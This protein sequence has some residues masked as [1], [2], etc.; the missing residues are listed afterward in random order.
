MTRRLFASRAG[1]AGG[2]ALLLIGLLPAPSASAEVLR[3]TS[4][5]GQ[6]SYTDQSC[7]PGTRRS[8]PVDLPPPPPPGSTMP[9][10]TPTPATA[11]PVPTG[12]ILL[13]ARRTQPPAPPSAAAPD[14]LWSYGDPDAAFEPAARPLHRPARP[15]DMRPR[16]RNCDAQGCNDTQGNHYNHQGQLDR[17]RALDGKTCRPVGTTTVCR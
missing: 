7:P 8:T 6:V 11:A 12:P 15:R 10:E 4:A 3:C 1:F 14:G 9:T 13:D 16:I 5:S 2:V 17:Y